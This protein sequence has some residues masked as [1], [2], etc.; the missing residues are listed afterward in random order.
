MEVKFMKRW[1]V[2]GTLLLVV[3]MWGSTFFVVHDATKHWNPIAFVALRFALAS[4]ALLP[5]ALPSLRRWTRAD[6]QAGLILGLLLTAGYITQ[7]IGI[8]L[9]T[10]SRSGFITGL[11]VVMVPLLGS[12]LWRTR[13]RGQVWL[14]VALAVAGLLVLSLD[15]A[16]G[17]ARSSWWGDGLV[18]IC[19]VTFAGHILAVGRWSKGRS[20]VA[21]NFI[22]MATVAVLSAAASLLF[23]D[24]TAAPSAD[25]W[26]A[27]AYLGVIC[28]A[29][30]LAIQIVAQR[31]ASPTHTAMIFVL[32]PV[33]A[34][35]FAAMFGGERLTSWL[36]WGG[37]LMLLGIVLAELP[38]LGRSRS[39]LEQSVE[40]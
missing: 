37:L 20:L 31:Y 7:T 32:E 14:G 28:T 13:V 1:Q 33:F 27:A 39:T 17:S 22:Q 38:A 9:T 15:Q 21:I 24:V 25:V 19:A 6:W 4:A 35:M 34:A 2:D 36:I 23:E 8:S 5:W 12:L 29:L 11:N 18:L 16:E 40:G 3:M 10:A 30:L 26:W